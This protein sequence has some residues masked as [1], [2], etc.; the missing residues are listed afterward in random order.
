[1][2]LHSIIHIIFLLYLYLSIFLLEITK[3]YEIEK[4][5][6]IQKKIVKILHYKTNN[7]DIFKIQENATLSEQINK[8]NKEKTTNT[9]I[10]DNNSKNITQKNKTTN[11]NLKKNR[12]KNFKNTNIVKN[13][14]YHNYCIIKNKNYLQ[15]YKNFIQKI[16]KL[17]K[18]FKIL[19]NKHTQILQK[20]TQEN[21]LQK[22]NRKKTPY[23]QLIP[24][25]LQAKK[26]H[27]LFSL[28][29]KQFFT[30]HNMYVKQKKTSLQILEIFKI[31]D[32]LR[33]QTKW[34]N[35]SST[36][37]E[38][39]YT[40]ISKKLPKTQNIHN[41][42]IDIQN[43][44]TKKTYYTQK[45]QK[46]FTNLQK[47]N[48]KKIFLYI[49][50]QKNL[51]DKQ[52][53]IH[54]KIPY[55]LLNGYNIQILEL[56][57]LKIIN[58][59]LQE[60]I[61]EI[62]AILHRY[63]FWIP[64]V[65]PINFV[66]FYHVFQDLQKLFQKNIIQQL[67]IS[68]K[69]IIAKKEFFVLVLIICIII[70]LKL[71]SHNHYNNFLKQ[72]SKKVGKV[73]Q[74]H[75]SLTLYNIFYS[76]LMSLPY[77]TLLAILGYTLKKNYPYSIITSIGE[78]IIISAPILLIYI[79][80]IYLSYPKGLFLI[81]F[82]WSYKKIKKSLHYC[83]I[84]INIIIP[85]IILLETFNNYNNNEF[86]DTL[87]RLSFI[88]LCT[89]LTVTKINL[90]NVGILIYLNKNS[91]Q[92]HI[93]NHLLWNIII[94]SPII[95]IITA[96]L[97]HLFTA[98]I[99]LIHLE[100]SIFIWLLLLIIYYTIRRWMFIHRRR[101]AFERAKKR[102]AKMLAQRAKKDKTLSESQ[103][104]KAADEVDKKILD[105]DTIS[106]QSLELIR[107]VLTLIS[108]V[109]IIFL[110]SD[111]H[112][113]FFFLEN[114]TLW[115]VTS[116]NIQNI[117]HI[118]PITLNT[119]LITIL[120]FII[121]SQI[122]RNL[123]ALLELTLLQHLNLAP[124][125]GYAI[126]TLTKYSLMLLGC[127][128]G[129]AI[130]GIEWSTLQWLIAAL[131]VGLGFGLQEIFANFISGLM[132]LFEKPIRI[133]DTVTIRKLT[134][135]ITKI[136]IRATTI[137]DWDKKEIIVPNK[138]FITEQFTNWSLSDTITRIVLN[139]PAPPHANMKQIIKIILKA[140]NSCPLIIRSPKPEVFLVDLHKGIPF[141]E[142]RIYVAEMRHRM[143][144][145]HQIHTKIIKNYKKF[146]IE[147]PYQP[148]Q[149]INPAILSEKFSRN[150]YSK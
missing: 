59:Q 133:G 138:A 55:F 136:N 32:I 6:N 58:N 93:I 82:N 111:L 132:I 48:K 123:P 15:Y 28:L 67:C 24:N 1:M 74:D 119:I 96:C 5:H 60:K 102:R 130:I 38:I 142:L 49:S 126:T 148:I 16:N 112:S 121:T 56:I 7:N 20:N 114:I 18:K 143:P 40:K 139:I 70:T 34:I 83:K 99:L 3:K 68:C 110:W 127:I 13:K 14:Y 89:C 79:I 36:L 86:S 88:L 106:A 134:G 17:E 94:Y 113:T 137:T 66:F 117:N 33:E 80:S 50:K 8:Y 30:I 22:T 122:V 101:I 43:T 37:N 75:F 90:K 21:A 54:K 104:N 129:F 31:L 72:S 95:L 35:F 41:I 27:I 147:L 116:N 10:K 57:K 23:N 125:T 4:D 2:I 26:N 71:S 97:G 69:N 98:K 61:K 85:L 100:I 120:I 145:R 46:N 62:Q 140:A 42:N 77:P 87:E 64:N 53:N 19:S 92:N 103:L 44:K 9:S 51:F 107:S 11:I 65:S 118:Q 78:G 63:L 52:Y 135:N 76:I 146:G 109:L 45:I 144:I 47:K 81:H 141:F 115:E 105:L 108:L 12:K 131:G 149:F 124:G 128:T 84:F 39:L 91:N 150:P 73:N 29:N 25:I